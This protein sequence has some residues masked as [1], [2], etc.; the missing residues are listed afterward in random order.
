MEQLPQIVITIPSPLESSKGYRERII[1]LKETAEG[2]MSVATLMEIREE[3]DAIAF[4]LQELE[5]GYYRGMLEAEDLIKQYERKCIEI[6]SRVLPYNRAENSAK[7]E[8]A[9]LRTQL[10]DVDAA[11]NDIKG[12][13]F[14]LKDYLEGL[15]QKIA[16]MRK[17]E[18]SAA[19]RE[20]VNP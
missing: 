5:A 15:R 10:V 16:A 7:L 4:T 8:T 18:E 1:A 13:R 9:G 11:H 2:E 6:Q 19:Y 17:E 3:L 20:R 14:T 12:L